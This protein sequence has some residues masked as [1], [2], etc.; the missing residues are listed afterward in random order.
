MF[1]SLCIIIREQM[2]KR[3][4]RI[5]RRT[6]NG[7]SRRSVAYGERTLSMVTAGRGVRDNGRTHRAANLRNVPVGGRRDRFTVEQRSSR[8][9]SADVPAVANPRDSG[10]FMETRAVGPRPV[11]LGCGTFSFDRR[12]TVARP[13]V[14]QLP[15]GRPRSRR[16]LR[17]RAR[18]TR[19]TWP[20]AVRG[21]IG[22]PHGRRGRGRTA[23]T[24]SNGPAGRRGSVERKARERARTNG[25]V[26]Y[27]GAS[28]RGVGSR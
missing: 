9:F 12:P 18:G 17:P 10:P 2:L 6:E 11:R 25:S 3:R 22:R 15:I 4:S 26:R 19:T 27:A 5:G 24:R 8:G 21:T 28:C 1:R 16:V 23:T 20:V 7:C 13:S 14:T